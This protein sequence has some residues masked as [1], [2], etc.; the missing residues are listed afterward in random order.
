MSTRR[1]S[2]MKMFLTIH[3]AI[4][5]LYGV[6]LAYDLATPT[7]ISTDD[8]GLLE[9]CRQLC[10]EY[11]LV[12]TG[13]VRNDA[14]AYLAA[15]GTRQL[16]EELGAILKDE[17]FRPVTTQP[18]RLIQQPAPSFTLSDSN[19]APR[20]LSEWSG[21]PLVLVFYYGYGCSHCV[22]QLFAINEDLHL[23]R[24]LGAEV[25]ALSSDSPEHTREKYA[26]YGA[27]NFPVLSDPENKVAAAYGVADGDRLDHGTFV[28][29]RHGKVVWAY[30]GGT[31]FLDNRTLLHVLAK[32]DLE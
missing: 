4:A 22:A 2:A 12:P 15:T 19:D 7:P 31:P 10:A 23:L 28:I 27:F 20:S 16:T 24:E 8:A 30:Q 13:H 1:S 5:A 17:G 18:H 14:E 29:D 25:I 3:G 32:T 6:I 21:R 26:E 9:A 11:G